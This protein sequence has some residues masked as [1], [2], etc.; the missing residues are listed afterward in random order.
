MAI[1]TRSRHSSSLD[2]ALVATDKLLR[3]WG[4]GADAIGGGGSLHPL[5][6]IRLLRDG[7]VFGRGPIPPPKE[8][9]VCDHV[10]ASSPEDTQAFLKVWYRDPFTPV[11]VKADRLGI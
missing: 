11:I 4:T 3:M 5:E 6:K 7:A 2:P 9:E 10:I 8:I 1:E